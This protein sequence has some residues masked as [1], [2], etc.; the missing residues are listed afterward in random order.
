MI[1][2]NGVLLAEGERF[3]RD[4]ELI[5]ARRRHRAAARR[6]RAADLLRRR[7]ARRRTAATAAVPLAPIPAPPDRPLLRPVE[8]HPFV[9]GRPRDARRAL[10]RGLLDPDGRPRAPGRAHA[11]ASGSCS[12]SRAGSTRRSRS[13]SARARWTCSACPAQGCSPSRCPAS[14]RARARSRAPGGLAAG[15][16]RGA[17]R[18]RHQGRLRAAHP[19]H[20]PRPRRPAER[21]L[22]EPAGARAHAGADGPRQQGRRDRGRHRRPLGAGARLRDLRRRPHRDVQRERERAQDAGAPAR[23]VGRGAPRERLGARGAAGRA[24]DARSRPSSCRPTATARSRSG[25]R[26]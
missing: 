22:P 19:G 15:L 8:P 11:G 4:G 21:H 20:R 24:R 26:T 1:A 14:A 5:V 17:A 23:G 3:R 2:E 13:S 18:D 9:A 7:P 12:A 10:P 6:A 16:G 25:P